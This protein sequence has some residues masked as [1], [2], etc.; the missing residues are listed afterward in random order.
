[1]TNINC[2]Y[3]GRKGL[4]L[5]PVRYAVAC[6]NGQKD[7]PGLSG[8]FKIIG[9]PQNAA[10]AKYTLRALRPG[11]LY[12]YEEKLK[13]LKAYIVLPQ[14]ALW[15]FPVEY[16]PIVN[17]YSMN[18]C[19]LD[20]VSA[21]LSYCIDVDPLSCEMMGNIWIG[22]SSSIWTKKSVN[23]VSDGNWRKKH[24]Q[25]IDIQEML[26]GSAPHA[27][28]FKEVS[29][30][31][32]Q[33]S[34]EDTEL[35]KAFDFSSILASH[36]ISIKEHYT[37]LERVME[38]RCPYGG[39]IV[40]VN[41][42][43]GITNDLSELTSPTHHAGFDEEIF[44]GHMCGQLIRSVEN[45]IR[46]DARDEFKKDILFRR[47]LE[48]DPEAV[49]GDSIRYLW[50]VVKAGGV[51]KYSAQQ[52]AEKKKYGD[53]QK[54]KMKAAE[55][56][57]WR[58]FTS[59][60]DGESFL[61]AERIRSFPS[62]Y[63]DAAKKYEPTSL[64]LANLHCSWLKSLQL[65]NW[66]SGVHDP[67]DI[68]SGSAYRESLAQCIGNGITTSACQEKLEE[69]LTSGDISSSGNLFARAL[70]FNQE[71]LIDAAMID[72]RGSDF[73]PKYLLSLYKQ[74]LGRI[75]KHEANRL[76]DRL[77]LTT[78]GFLAR[79]LGQARS[80]AMRNLVTAGLVLH[81]KTMIKPSGLTREQLSHWILDS[82]KAQGV[83]LQQLSFESNIN[84]QREAKR[85]LPRYPAAPVVCA[86]ELDVENLKLERKIDTGIL[87]TV[88][89][90]DLELVKNWF[91]N[92]DVN[93]GSVGVVL[94][95]LA[96]YYINEDRM[97]AD[98]VDRNTQNMKVAVASLAVG[99]AALEAAATALQKLPDN[100]LSKFIVNQWK[101]STNGIS[102]GI[103]T[104]KFFGA[105]ASG[106]SAL[107]DFKNAY[108]AFNDG[109][110]VLMNL[111]IVNASLAIG[112]AIAG[113]KWTAVIYWPLFIAAFCLTIFIST[114]RPPAIKKWL[115]RSYFS[116]SNASDSE[117]RYSSIDEELEAFNGAIGV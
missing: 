34:A 7:V 14:G 28:N 84:A 37:A 22:W 61:D 49:T 58:E 103:Q 54:G 66:M 25:S 94:Q 68:R 114:I 117:G 18:G 80:I 71:E 43:V 24:M 16:V 45:A 106:L 116:I 35:K 57:A 113:F 2:S 70:L 41:D 39:F 86:F 81:G 75:P 90:P 40:A 9:A 19:C 51:N 59:H 109:D 91:Q 65:S 92:G 46:N 10:P 104:G 4:L 33:F 13:R 23:K 79:A 101:F 30:N 112:L 8:N 48:N 56:R 78:A 26:V 98:E 102:Y 1:M 21:A 63:V 36:D 72:I 96:L 89:I 93:A 69:W 87:K 17:P 6:P 29:K 97:R 5:Y 52:K 60:G 38:E 31:V 77:V 20:R 55:E 62:R 27:G 107:F 47:V 100:P 64:T 76:V 105:L 82:A 15:E 50:N 110:I 44:R 42:P 85:V 73:K 108:G 12:T 83:Q 11:Y 99:A 111:Y 74:V 3:C 32:P 95:L 53:S 67:E 88:K 115:A